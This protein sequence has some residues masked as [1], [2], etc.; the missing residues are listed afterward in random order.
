MNITTH[1]YYEYLNASCTVF[2]SN[3]TTLPIM[4]KKKTIAISDKRSNYVTK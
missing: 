4:W 2:L 1:I 3:N